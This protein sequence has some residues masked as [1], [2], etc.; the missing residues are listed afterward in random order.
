MSSKQPTLKKP[1]GPFQA[2]FSALARARGMLY[3]AR[4]NM[5]M[6]AIL[7][8]LAVS[9]VSAGMAALA[10]AVTG[11]FAGSAGRE[12]AG[13]V[14]GSLPPAWQERAGSFVE[15]RG[16]FVQAGPGAASAF[17]RLFDAG[18]PLALLWEG[19]SGFQ[20]VFPG[21]FPLDGPV[22]AGGAQTVEWRPRVRSPQSPVQRVVLETRQS[23]GGWQVVSDV[24]G[25]VRG[26]REWV[27]A[28]GVLSVGLAGPV[29]WLDAGVRVWSEGT[30]FMIR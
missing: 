22:A 16:R 5:K 29:E 26:V 14:A 4:D 3:N 11:G 10:G 25:V 9:A 13:E 21:E 20:V 28:G 15:A 2:G 30:V 6:K 8:A 12:Q 1:R 7:W 27:E 17:V 18:R 23:N 19:A 24:K